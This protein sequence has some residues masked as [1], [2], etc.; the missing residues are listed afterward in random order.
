[1][2]KYVYIYIYIYTVYTCVCIYLFIYMR[3]IIYRYV[4]TSA[5]AYTHAR[6]GTH[7]P[8]PQK[9]PLKGKKTQITTNIII[10]IL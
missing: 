9:T 6:N 8:T 4:H 10:L 5:R 7:A 2:N 1:M 3:T